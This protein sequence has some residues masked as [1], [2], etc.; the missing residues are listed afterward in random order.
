VDRG[1]PSH[2]KLW[3]LKRN[4]QLSAD[5]LPRV[6]HR[7]VLD[8]G[9]FGFNRWQDAATVTGARIW[10]FDLPSGQIVAAVSLDTSC[11]LADTIDLLEDCYFADITIAGSTVTDHVHALAVQLGA[12]GTAESEF[13]PERHQVVLDKDVATD[14]CED[15]VQRL[16]YRADLPY[17]KEHSAIR[18][19]AELN[20]RPGWLAA[21]G[22]YVSVVCGH[23]KFIENAIFI[24]TVQAVAAAAQLRAIRQAAYDDVRLFRSLEAAPGSTR[25]RRRTL[26]RIADQLGDL[27]LEL[28]FS[29]EATGDLGLLVP[30]LRVESF[31]NALYDCMGLAA[32][33]VTVEK[34]MQRL[35][36]AIAA[37]LTAI[38]SIERRSDENRRLRYTVAVGFV[39]VVAIPA[40]LILAFLGINASQVNPHL[41]MFSYHYLPVYLGVAALL[42]IGA[43]L[44]VAL[45]VQHRRA[46]RH[47]RVTAPRP[48]WTPTLEPAEE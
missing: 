35:S 9:Q 10:L 25:D 4:Y 6:L 22:P 26:E 36:A 15:L 18:Y 20:R 41:S 19:P 8:P 39:S 1:L 38:E 5:Q 2:L 29:V 34:M 40:S 37:E 44:S 3:R 23:P 28:S 45:W 32:K 48:R 7:A 31:H 11:E 42:A 16:I 43:L 21:L 30:S 47:Q 13:L 27:E 14:D 17:R 24:S 12:D 46:Q 33:A